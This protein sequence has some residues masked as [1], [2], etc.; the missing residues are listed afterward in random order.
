MRNYAW[1]FSCLDQ[2]SKHAEAMGKDF[3]YSKVT[4]AR[5]TLRDELWESIG[6]EAQSHFPHTLEHKPR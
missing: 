3:L 2:V 6:S 1:V 4:E 5:S